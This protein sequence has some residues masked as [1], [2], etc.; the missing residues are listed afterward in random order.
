MP[1]ERPTAPRAITRS[2][3]LERPRDQ[4]CAGGDRM[5]PAEFNYPIPREFLRVWEEYGGE[6]ETSAPLAAL[7]GL[8][9]AEID[10]IV[11][12]PVKFAEL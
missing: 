3:D 4:T 7:S 5:T 12:N 9:E 6:A 11:N 1:S 8:R 10:A 2:F